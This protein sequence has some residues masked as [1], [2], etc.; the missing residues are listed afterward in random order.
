[1]DLLG[2]STESIAQAGPA[3]LRARTLAVRTLVRILRDGILLD[4]ALAHPKADPFVHELLY[5]V[6]RHYYSLSS[7]VHRRLSRTL[8]QKDFDIFCLLLAGTYQLRHMRIPTHAAVHTSVEVSRRLGKPWAAKLVNAVLRAVERDPGN[9]K[10]LEAE[11]DHPSWLMELLREQYPQ[12]WRSLLINNLSRAPMS[13]R[14][15]QA[16]CSAQECG[17]LLQASGVSAKPGLVPGALVLAQPV[18]SAQVPAITR[19]LASIQDEGAQ[20]AALLLAPKAGMRVLDA[21]AAPGNKSTHLLELAPQI[22]LTCIDPSTRRLDRLLSECERLRLPKPTVFNAPLEDLSWWDG[23]AFDAIL[24]D[25]PCSG[26]GTLRRHPDIKLRA[27]QRDLASHQA[28]QSRLVSA[29]WRTLSIGGH[30]LYSTCSMLRQ[31]NDDSLQELSARRDALRL[32]TPL[33]G[34]CAVPHLETKL[35]TQLLPVDGGPDAMYYSLFQK[36]G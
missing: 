34:Q 27:Q 33:I 22:S 15:N 8:R 24:L 26:T 25:V 7:R 2:D 21:C 17:T 18:P 19:G 6:C 9:P 28:R 36:A 16:R 1:M 31:E 13:L 32:S 29:A 10:G 5:G 30:L 11:L 4:Q 12:A 20:L 35:G 14:V 23:T 3:R